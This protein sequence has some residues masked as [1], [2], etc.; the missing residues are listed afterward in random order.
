MQHRFII[1]I[2]GKR[3]LR[4]SSM[5]EIGDKNGFSAMGMTVAAPTAIGAELIL[6]T[7]IQERGVLRPIYKDIYEPCLQRLEKLGIR[8]VDEV[9]EL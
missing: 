1:E 7:A 6:E 3:Y 5:I 8:L 9:E 2:N 4:K